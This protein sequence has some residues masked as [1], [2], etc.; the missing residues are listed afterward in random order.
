MQVNIRQARRIEQTVGEK[1]SMHLSNTNTFSLY[2]TVPNLSDLEA[3]FFIEV[4]E[5]QHLID[6]RFRIRKAIAIA[7]DVSGINKLMT[8]EAGLKAQV[9]FLLD[10]TPRGRTTFKNQE[11]LRKEFEI[12]LNRL[13]SEEQT[14][15]GTNDS[16]NI[17]L[18]SEA[19]VAKMEKAVAV[20][21]KQQQAL[22]DEMLKLNMTTMVEISDEDAVFLKDL[23]LL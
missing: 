20:L 23:N 4:A 5:K 6:V 16:I 19:G 14:R 18:L 13:Q 12:K 3:D 21:K 9:T 15:Y 22:A 2:G 1:I 11:E 8:D 7:N 17:L 10:L